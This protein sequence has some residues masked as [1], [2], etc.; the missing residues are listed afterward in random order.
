MPT[1]THSELETLAKHI[2]QWGKSLGFQDVRI[3]DPDLSAYESELQQWLAAGYHGEMGYME[4][5]G[6]LRCRPDALHPGTIR[7]ISV[8]MDYLP[9]QPAFAETL[10][11]PHS[12]YIS[13]YAVGRDYHKLIRKRL[14]QLG[15]QIEQAIE[16]LSY[17]PFVD[18]APILER[19]LA[20]KAGLG[21]I[22][23]HTLLLN[24]SAGSFFFLGEL[25]VNLPLPKDDTTQNACGRCVACMKICPTQAIIAPYTLDARRCISYLTI[26]HSGSI[27]V[28]LRTALGNRIY[29]CDDCQL[30]CPWNHYAQISTEPDFAF[31][32]IW[33]D[34]SLLTLFQWDEPTFLAN[35]AGTPIRRIGY[36]RWQRNLAVAIGNAPY[37]EALLAA[38]QAKPAASE[39]VQ[40][41]IE[42]AISQQQAKQ[43]E[44]QRANRLTQRLIRSIQKGLPVDNP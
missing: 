11:Q 10:A 20:E 35:T 36:Q 26:E 40:E 23:K 37:D 5:H 21:W 3:C 31:K 15:K 27:P 24:E 13:R 39:M 28:E 19:P 43:S 17:R 29:G 33:A 14:A 12:G 22:G 7:I 1:S 6:D 42:W 30:I 44:V 16:G 18:S 2:K 32:P 8:R 9:P 25:L 38:L 4:N 41:H 34:V